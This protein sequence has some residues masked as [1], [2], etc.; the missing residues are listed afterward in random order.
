MSNRALILLAGGAAFLYFI[1]KSV[2]NL[3]RLTFQVA[4]LKNFNASSGAVSVQ[5]DILILNPTSST[6]P[7]YDTV[8][9]ADVLVNNFFVGKATT[10]VNSLLLPG[11]QIIVPLLVSMTAGNFAGGVAALI[12]AFQG[13]GTRVDIL[14]NVLV[15]GVPLPLNLR[16]NY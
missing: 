7:L 2:M 16:Y 8:I 5:V 12:A 6:F 10:N 11:Q 13:G 1:T 9:N 15:K 14:G 3:N 4:G